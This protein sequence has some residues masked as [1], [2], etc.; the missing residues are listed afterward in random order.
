METENTQTDCNEF[1]DDEMV[2]EEISI[3]DYD[4]SNGFGMTKSVWQRTI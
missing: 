2:E 1:A 4:M 3:F